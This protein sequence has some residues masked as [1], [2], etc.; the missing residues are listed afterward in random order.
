MRTGPVRQPHADWGGECPK[1]ASGALRQTQDRLAPA[2]GVVVKRDVLVRLTV[3]V[4]RGNPA[5]AP[6]L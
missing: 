4:E 2:A 1:T 3:E 5:Q 6:V